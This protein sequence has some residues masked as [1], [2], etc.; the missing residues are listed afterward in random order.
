MNSR[1]LPQ[2]NESKALKLTELQYDILGIALK[3]EA[4]ITT[5]LLQAKV[6]NLQRTYLPPRLRKVTWT[7][8]QWVVPF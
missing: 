6:Q 8:K 5:I 4:K 1:S 3:S 7:R 2:R